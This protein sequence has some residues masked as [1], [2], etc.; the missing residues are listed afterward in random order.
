MTVI[1]A[2][3]FEGQLAAVDNVTLTG[4]AS[5]SSVQER[6]GAVSLRC[7]PASGA[8]GRFTVGQGGGSY[9]H[10]GLYIA[11]LPSVD[12]IIFWTTGAGLVNIRLTSAGA[13]AY[14]TNTTLIGTTAAISTGAWYWVGVRILNATSN[15]I[16]QVDGADALTGTT[17][18]QSG[19][20]ASF[21]CSGTEASAIDIYIDDIVSDTQA[22]SPRPR[23]TSRSPSMTTE[24]IPAGDW[25]GRLHVLVGRDLPTPRP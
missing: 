18:S 19:F 2:T 4:T 21:G 24:P 12:R 20:G 13:L 15:P 1:F 14:Y 8:S 7:N 17:T 9:I 25:R 16:I 11:S 3:G 6:T 23:W 22:S 5:Y 10:F